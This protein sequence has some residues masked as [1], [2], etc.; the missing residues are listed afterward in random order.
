MEDSMPT[1]E[2]L[3][4]LVEDISPGA[5][6]LQS[7]TDAIIVSGRITDLADDLVG[8]FVELAREAGATWAVNL[9]VGLL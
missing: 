6:P 7:L 5:D 8:H 3:I 4:G 9:G 2:E 1:L